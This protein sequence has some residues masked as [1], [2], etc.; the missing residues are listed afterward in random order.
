MSHFQPPGSP[1]QSGP[2]V[3][4]SLSQQQTQSRR[5]RRA[6]GRQ[7]TQRPVVLPGQPGQPVQPGQ[8]GQPGLPQRQAQQVGAQRATSVRLAQALAGARAWA[9]PATTGARLA[10]FAIDLVAVLLV[11]ALVWFGSHSL[12]LAVLAVLETAVV[13]AF[14]EARTGATL[15][16]LALRIRTVRDDAPYS[17]GVGRGFVRALVLGGGTL[18]A[19]I[20]GFVVVATS[21]ADPM[22]MGRSW[23]DRAGRSLVVRVPTNAEREAWA[24]G[25]EAWA[26]NA[27]A[28]PASAAPA[29]A[30]QTSAAPL[31]ERAPQAPQTNHA[32][33]PPRHAPEPVSSLPAG[34]VSVDAPVAAPPPVQQVVV[35]E[36]LLLTLDTGQRAQFPIPLALNLGRKPDPSDPADQLWIVQDPDSSVSKTHLRIESRGDSVWLTDLG[37]TNGSALLDETGAASPLAPG[38]RVR[39]EEGSRV[40]IG[41]RSFTVA[42]VVGEIQRDGRA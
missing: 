40:K 2:P 5:E 41:D 32:P 27:L 20:G 16:N 24:Q 10:A 34:V 17:P 6:A 12:V 30:A 39:L 29:S 25:A 42:T 28:A 4:P 9:R 35:G 36:Q 33:P 19:L 8:P 37:S 11:G 22:R 3:V 1:A 21:A 38:V 23:A 14:L 18:V 15:G 13:L 7:R 26:A 31:A